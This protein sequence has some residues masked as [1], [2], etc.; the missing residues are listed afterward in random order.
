[1]GLWINIRRSLDQ[2][3]LHRERC[4]QIPTSAGRSDHW[5][6]GWFEYPDKETALDALEQTGTTQQLKCPICKP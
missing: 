3:V 2:A 6:G 1:M 4:I 5:E